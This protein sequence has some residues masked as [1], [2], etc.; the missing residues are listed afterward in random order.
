MRR[1][2]RALYCGPISTESKIPSGRTNDAPCLARAN[3]ELLD[4]DLVVIIVAISAVE[5]MSRFGK[6]ISVVC[7][8]PSWECLL[9]TTRSF[10]EHHMQ[11]RAGTRI[12]LWA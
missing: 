2:T 7:S 12:K 6:G 4:L 1:A 10:S 8:S 5:A 9:K 3:W 11:R